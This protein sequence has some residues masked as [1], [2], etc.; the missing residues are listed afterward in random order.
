MFGP[1]DRGDD[2]LASK[3]RLAWFPPSLPGLVARG[4]D[5]RRTPQG[6]E[7]RRRLWRKRPVRRLAGQ[8]TACGRGAMRFWSA[9][10]AAMTRTAARIII[11]TKK[12]PKSSCWRAAS[13]A[14][15]RGKLEKPNPAGALVGTLGMRHG[16]LPPGSPIENPTDLHEPIDFAH[17]GFA[18]T[19]RME[20]SNA[21]MSRFLFFLRSRPLLARPFFAC[22]CSVKKA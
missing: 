21:G 8:S 5:G 2:G 17:P 3:R 13:M 20:N 6:L 19:V 4:R 10:A 9:S 12:C 22:R 1:E 18:M 14:A 7:T 16:I 15:S 11:S